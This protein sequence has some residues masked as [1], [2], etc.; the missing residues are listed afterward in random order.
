[1]IAARRASTGSGSVPTSRQAD[2][3]AGIV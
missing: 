1:V 3:T 2:R